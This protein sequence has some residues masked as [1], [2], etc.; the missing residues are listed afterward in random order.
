M[1]AGPIQAAAAARSSLLSHALVPTTLRVEGFSSE[2]GFC[3]FIVRVNVLSRDE[4]EIHHGS[5]I[6]KMH[7][8]PLVI[9]LFYSYFL[10]VFCCDY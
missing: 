2:M 3:L 6:P 9:S 10:K 5:S 1:R 7:A 4:S 8:S